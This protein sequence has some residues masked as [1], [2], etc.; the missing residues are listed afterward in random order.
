M[1]FGYGVAVANRA[2]KTVAQTG[3]RSPRAGRAKPGARGHRGAADTARFP[4]SR[5][6]RRRVL[7][8]NFFRSPQVA[9]S[10]AS[11][12]AELAEPPVAIVEVGAGS[13]LLTRV[14]S[15][16][17]S[18]VLAVEMDPFWARSLEDLDLPGV[19]VVRD[20]FVRWAPPPGRLQVIGN[21]PFGAGTKILRRCLDLGPQ[22]L[23]QAVLLMQAEVVRKRVGRWGSNLFNVQWAPWYELD[24]GRAFARHEFR[25]V[26]ATNAATLLIEPRE[27]ALMPWR[28]RFGY[29]NLARDVFGTGHLTLQAALRALEPGKPKAWLGRSGLQGSQRVKDLGVQDWVTLYRA[30][31]AAGRDH[32]GR[33]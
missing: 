7:G 1:A 27:P 4:A 11:Q 16:R 10:F 22:R 29:Q 31:P 30:A 24:V 28:E 26:P 18:P 13:G 8:Q 33:A 23:Q 17:H 6:A 21:I 20:D 2:N 12:L 15:E 5:D 9:R 14:L 19:T 32:R 25:P 3:A